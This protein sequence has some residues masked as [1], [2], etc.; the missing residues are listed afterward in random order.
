MSRTNDIWKHQQ[1]IKEELSK[2]I[3]D[4]LLQQTL[5]FEQSEQL[6]D[7]SFKKLTKEFSKEQ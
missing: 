4:S 3:K 5:K 2:E 6:F 7:E 1:K